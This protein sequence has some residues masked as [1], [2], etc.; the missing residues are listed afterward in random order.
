[1]CHFLGHTRFLVSY[2]TLL[3]ADL[4]KIKFPFYDSGHFFEAL[5]LYFCKIA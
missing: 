4:K 2:I 1:M 3:Q 5:Q